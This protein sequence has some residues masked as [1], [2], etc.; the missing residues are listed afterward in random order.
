MSCKIHKYRKILFSTPIDLIR[1]KECVQF[2]RHYGLAKFHYIVTPNVDHIVRINKNQNLRKIYESAVL[3][4]CDS[5]I[6]MILAKLCCVNIPCTIP[7][8]DLTR[9]MFEG[10]IKPEDNV[11]IIGGSTHSVKRLTETYKIFNIYHYNPPM[12]FIENEN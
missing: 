9:L 7:G 10:I 2:I 1:L 4:L 12:R 5:R 11:T 6:I 3:S 8:S